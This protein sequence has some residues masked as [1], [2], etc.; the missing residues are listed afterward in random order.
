MNGL[1]LQ[2]WPL[3]MT[4]YWR[5]CERQSYAQ[6]RDSEIQAKCFAAIG[7]KGR[8]IWPI[9]VLHFSGRLGAR[10]CAKKIL[11]L[12]HEPQNKI[13]SP[14]ASGSWGPQEI[15]PVK[16]DC[17]HPFQNEYPNE[18]SGHKVAERNFTESSEFLNEKVCVLVSL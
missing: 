15:T 8:K 10:N 12:F 6:C 9:F 17:V 1:C 11:E 4:Y 7:E 5:H 13:L 2:T 18:L 16:I 3:D 14:R